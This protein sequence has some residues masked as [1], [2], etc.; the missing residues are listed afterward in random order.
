MLA[1][2]RIRFD[3]LQRFAMGNDQLIVG[4]AMGGDFG[5]PKLRIGFP[6]PIAPKFGQLR[7]HIINI[8]VAPP[9]ILHPGKARELIHERRE[10]LFALAERFLRPLALGEV[11][12]DSDQAEGLALSVLDEGSDDVRRQRGLRLGAGLP[13]RPPSGLVP[14]IAPSLRAPGLQRAAGW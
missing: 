12:A 1:F 9:G 2:G 6:K 8:R 4:L 14:A 13:I 5:R 11:N 3:G 10:A 7:H